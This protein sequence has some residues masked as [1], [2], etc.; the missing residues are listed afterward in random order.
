M[1]A[2]L[3]VLLAGWLYLLFLYGL[4]DRDLWN[5]HEAR[6]GMDAQSL[7][8]GDGLL[9]RLYD[10]RPDLQ[11]PPL[12]YW[13]VAAVAR[14]RG[15]TVDA[16]AVRLPAALAAILCVGI[17]AAF[18]WGCGRPREG[19]LA[20]VMLATAVHF[21]WLGRVGRIDMP[22]TCAV[23]TTL[24][25]FSLA[26][27]D[28]LS[29][30]Y[31][32]G[33]LLTAYVC[34][35]VAVLLKGP[36]GIVLPVAAFGMHLLC[37]G[38][39]S[40]PWQLRRWGALV[41]R[42]GLWWGLPL[43]LT[44]TV[45]WF[46]WADH[47]TGGELAR[48][49][50]WHHNVERGLGGSSLREHPWWFYGPQFAVDFLPWSLLV[51]TAAWYFFRHGRWRAD[52]EA[53][54]GLAWFVAMAAVLSCAR[55]KRADYLVPAYPGA[56][57][58][59][60]CTLLRWYREGMAGGRSLLP[61]AA[62]IGLA[63]VLAA[64]CAGWWAR[65]TFFLPPL[66]PGREHRTFAALVRHHAPRP[67][68][69]VLFRTEAHV[70]AFHLGR[71]VRSLVFWEELDR[72]T[73]LSDANG[74]A[75]HFVIMPAGIARDWARCLG[76]VRL[77]E[78]ANNCQGRDGGH[79]KPLVLFRIVP[80]VRTTGEGTASPIRTVAESRS[81]ARTAE[82]AGRCQ[83]TPQPRPAGA[84]CRGALAGPRQEVGRPAA[85]ARGGT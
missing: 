6:A 85:R 17:V 4:A 15:G 80:R 54:L 20:A 41:H 61:R 73:L 72:I 78:I 53:R 64:V 65:V 30:R 57:L 59:L 22:L 67:E 58:F 2:V 26:E 39:G 55:Y 40:P 44:L 8:D 32:L 79:E 19:L 56:A 81:D 52:R 51:P 70:L 74:K 47:E 28:N 18:G 35:A 12:Y 45:P 68:P 42:L 21:T 27:R 63:V 76:R 66:E 5:S 69:V 48:V 13:L 25:C 3:F 37:E 62:P 43:L 36:I 77:E 83:A 49:F 75:P 34:L 33:L 23:A 71:P 11:K 38:K 31:R 10:D 50:L 16:W 9:P 84:R 1:R 24:A 46:W 7:L 60:G 82:V 14:L 29:R